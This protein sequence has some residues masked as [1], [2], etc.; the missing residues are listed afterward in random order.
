MCVTFELFNSDAVLTAAI[1]AEGGRLMRYRVRSMLH[2]DESF[3]IQG[4]GSFNGF[5]HIRWRLHAI[6]DLVLMID[7]A[8]ILALLGHISVTLMVFASKVGWFWRVI[9]TA[10]VLTTMS[11]VMVIG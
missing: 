10:I 4:R 5:T 7:A 8:E 9:I 3:T 11:M 6:F 1:T 2:I